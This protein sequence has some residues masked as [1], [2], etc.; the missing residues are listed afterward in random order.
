MER[1]F[2]FLRGGCSKDPVTLLKEAG[3]DLT[4]KATFEA[5]MQQFLGALEEFTS[6]S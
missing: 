5:A 6:L 1:Y 2:A 4:S 3:A